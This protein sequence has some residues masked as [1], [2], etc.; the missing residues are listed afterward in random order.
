VLA[1]AAN[2]QLVDRATAIALAKRDILYVPDFIANCGGIIHVGAEL[3]G[4]DDAEVDRRVQASVERVE[5]VLRVARD[6]GELPLEVAERQALAR[7]EAAHAR[8]PLRGRPAGTSPGRAS[9]QL[10]RLA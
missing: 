7:L 4:F 8:V 6:S 3:L 10:P 9:T 2:N 1:G 5:A